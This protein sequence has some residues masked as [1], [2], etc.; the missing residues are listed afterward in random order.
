MGLNAQTTVPA[1]TAGQILTAAQQTNINTGIPVF[2]DSSAR[3]AAFGGTGEKVLAE[4]QYAYLESD[5]STSFYDGAAWVAVGVTPGLVPITPTSIS[6][7]S[8]TATSAGNGQVTFTGVGTNLSLNGVFSATYTNYLVLIEKQ[9]A[10]GTAGLNA[11]LRFGTTDNANANYDRAELAVSQA[12]SVTGTGTNAGT[13]WNFNINDLAWQYLKINLYSPFVTGFTGMQS[14]VTE[15]NGTTS[16]YTATINGQNRES[17]SANGLT[18]VVASGGT[19]TGKVT[20]YGYT[21]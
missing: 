8:G 7:G 17:Y 13:Q 18:F 9:T 15:N 21:I 2:A 1:F 4:G 5:N 14:M 20:V 11:R 3:T 10:S 16:F 19:V 12:G 6:V